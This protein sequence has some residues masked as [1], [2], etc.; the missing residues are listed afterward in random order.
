MMFSGVIQ[1]RKQSDAGTTKDK[2]SF[3]EQGGQV[4]IQALSD[5]SFPPVRLACDSSHR[6]DSHGCVSP[7]RESF[8]QSL[9][10]CIQSRVQV[11]FTCRSRSTHSIGFSQE[12]DVPPSSHRYRQCVG[13]F[14]DVLPSQC[15]FLLRQQTGPRRRD[16]IRSSTQVRVGS[17]N[18]FGS[19]ETVDSRVFA[20]ITFAMLSVG[21]S[22]AM[23]P[24]YSK[25]KTAALRILR[26]TKRQSEINPHDESGIIL[27]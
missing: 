27:V 24:D 4:D 3:T 6:A 11:R 20:V 23:I 2:G 1:G 17:T 9:R 26:L 22:M 14:N 21:R 16:A 12:T 19:I 7:S 10:K 5:R 8:H 13:Q 18:A 25:A 15:Q